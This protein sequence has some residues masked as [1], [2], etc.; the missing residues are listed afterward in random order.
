MKNLSDF[1]KRLAVGVKLHAIHHKTFAGRDEQGK[2]VYSDKDLG[3]REVS[4]VQSN[5]FALKTPRPDGIAVNSWCGYPKASDVK[6]VDAD[7]IEIYEESHPSEA[8]Q[9]N[10]RNKILTYRFV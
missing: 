10:G 3:V 8:V 4:I 5:S 6:I 1:K 9:K 7:T 2:T